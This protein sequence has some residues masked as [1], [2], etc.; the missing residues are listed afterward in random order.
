MAEPNISTGAPAPKTPVFPPPS[1]LKKRA[2]PYRIETRHLVIRCYELTD[3]PRLQAAVSAS[4]EHL[5]T[6]MPWAYNEPQTLDQKVEL[7]RRFRGKFDLAEDFVYGVFSP[8]ERELWG[9]TGFHE[10]IGPDALE[11]GYWIHA[12]QTRR[13]YATELSAALTRVGIELVEARKIEIRCDVANTVS[14]KVP[15]R[16]GY[17]LDATLRQAVYGS[18]SGMRDCTV[19]SMLAEELAGSPVATAAKDVRAF[20]ALGREVMRGQ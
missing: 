4:V 1:M 15:K 16:L 2:M 9:G 5:Q 8:D 18:P 19:W 13:G 17:R 20:D 14:A 12:A 6:F 10:R 3:A 7:L 11:I